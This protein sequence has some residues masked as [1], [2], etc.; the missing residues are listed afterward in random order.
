MKTLKTV[1][2]QKKILKK[3]KES[4]LTPV[5]YVYKTLREKQLL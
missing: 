2:I 5:L 3:K 1:H 4:E